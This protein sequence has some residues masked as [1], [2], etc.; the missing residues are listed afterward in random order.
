MCIASFNYTHVFWRLKP[1]Y[2][3]VQKGNNKS[4]NQRKLARVLLSSP[5]VNAGAA[6][7]A[8][9]LATGAAGVATVVVVVFIDP[10]APLSVVVVT[11][12]KRRRVCIFG[13]EKEGGRWMVLLDAWA[14]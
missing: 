12:N 8:A 2:I 9:G 14:R 1:G 3:N 11:V 6:A 4:F 10:P 7:G 13:R 5:G